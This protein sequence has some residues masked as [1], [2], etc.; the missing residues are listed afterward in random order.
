MERKFAKEND[1]SDDEDEVMRPEQPEQPP[2]TGSQ[3]NPTVLDDSDNEKDKEPEES[4]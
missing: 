2:T 1:S 3:N 4:R